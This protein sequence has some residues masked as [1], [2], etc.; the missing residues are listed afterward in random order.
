MT[1]CIIFIHPS[2]DE[3]KRVFIDPPPRQPTGHCEFLDRNGD[4]V[5]DLQCLQNSKRNIINP[6]PR[7]PTGLCEQLDSNGDIRVNVACMQR[8]G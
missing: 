4:I 1:V 6:P 8:Q 2:L 7:Q 5:R 3:E